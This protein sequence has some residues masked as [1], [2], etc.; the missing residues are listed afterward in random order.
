MRTLAVFGARFMAALTMMRVARISLSSRGSTPC[1][2]SGAAYATPFGATI[3][4]HVP[5]PLNMSFTLKT[6]R[7]SRAASSCC[8]LDCMVLKEHQPLYSRP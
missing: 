8:G 5:C 4:L 2:A 6:T 1:L 7:F 3:S